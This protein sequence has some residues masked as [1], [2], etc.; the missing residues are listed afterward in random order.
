MYVTHTMPE[1]CLLVVVGTH[2][3]M[4]LSIHI[5]DLFIVFSMH[6]NVTEI[7]MDLFPI[8]AE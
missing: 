6:V 2:T 7:H 5:L 8:L 4:I 1:C 3:Q